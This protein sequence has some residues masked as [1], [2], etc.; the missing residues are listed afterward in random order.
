M[1]LNKQAK[2]YSS[3]VVTVIFNNFYVIFSIS[4]NS[5]V[6]EA[7]ECS[8][9]IS[10]ISTVGTI[11]KISNYL[12]VLQLYQNVCIHISTILLKISFCFNISYV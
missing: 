4:K 3:S 7:T 5:N 11:S 8:N 10:S 2:Q 6:A 9:I 12:Q 1:S